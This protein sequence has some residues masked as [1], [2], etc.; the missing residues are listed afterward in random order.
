M[1]HE[2]SNP[3]KT[4]VVG[5][6]AGLFSDGMVHPL[7][8]IRARAQVAQKGSHSSIDIIKKLHFKSYYKGFTAVAIGT[9]PGHAFYFCGYE[10]SKNFA[11]NMLNNIENNNPLVHLT[12]GLVADICGG[13]VWCPMEVVKQ[14]VQIH[15]HE[16][17]ISVSKQILAKDGIFGFFRGYWAGIF[18]YAPYVMLYFALYERFKY[19]ARQKLN[20]EAHQ[21][22]FKYYIASCCGASFIAAGV[23]TPVD[24]IRT[25]IQTTT[26]NYTNI[27]DGARTILKEES[28]MTFLRGIGPRVAWMGFGT[29]TTLIFYEYF[30]RH[31]DN[32]V[33]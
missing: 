24:V 7:D 14:R 6:A 8:T 15:A 31:W 32:I 16:T 22:P 30:S 26:G 5:A 3:L 23:T 12:A 28:P 20:V 25:R 2:S 4:L 18:T 10:A 11:N 9:V 13:L 27:I 29:A 33:N 21:V 1:P 19:I 17:P